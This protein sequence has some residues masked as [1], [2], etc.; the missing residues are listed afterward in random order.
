MRERFS[1]NLARLG[2]K[3]GDTLT[4]ALSGGLDSVVLLALLKEQR[5]CLQAAHVHHGIRGES[6]DRDARFCEAL[7]QSWKIPFT[8]LKGDA[9]AFSKERGMS[10]EEGARAMRYQLLAPFE[11]EG[12]LATA[13]HA[14]DDA[15]TFFINLYRGSGSAGLSGIP[16]RRGRLIRPLLPFSK[17]EL[18]LFAVREGFSYC[19]DE[20]NED[21]SFLRNFLRLEILP[22]L[23]SREEGNF[24]KGLAASMKHLKEEHEAL[25]SWADSVESDEQRVLCALPAAVLKRV[26]DRM[27]GG[28]LSRVHFD[29]IR[30]LLEGQA[31][32]GRL[33]IGEGRYFALEYGRCRFYRERSPVELAIR[34]GERIA[35]EGE[36]FEIYPW[37]INT[38]FTKFSIDC[39]KIG[40]D[41]VLRHRREGDLFRPVGSKG[42]TS[43]LQKRLKNDQM[44][45]SA[46]D[47]LWLL[48]ERSGRVLWVEHYG[49]DAS[50]ACD[51]GTKCAYC[52]EIKEEGK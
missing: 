13:H 48:A 9:P 4:V 31:Q 23:D 6:A 27:N 21:A 33:Q 18:R 20:T 14:G 24:R 28:A 37:E 46:R 12:F 35:Y 22:R 38:P 49:A 45:R 34:P 32:C 26:L 51:G 5:L 42:S 1:E 19:K 41:L 30:A 47:A 25:Q 10:L 36:E 11:Q 16:A 43:R 7:C 15:E 29:E 40:N 2:V 8:L 3:E 52:I 39:D 50:A 44:G 17:E